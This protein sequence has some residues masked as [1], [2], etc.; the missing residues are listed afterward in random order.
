MLRASNHA[1]LAR[2]TGVLAGLLVA[3]YIG[4]ESPVSGMSMNPART[5]GS[6]LL[7]R[8]WTALW[9][10]F[11]APLAGML[12]AAKVFARAGARAACA[13]LHHHNRKRCI[14]NCN[15]RE[16][17]GRGS[18]AGEDRSVEVSGS[19]TPETAMLLLAS[20]L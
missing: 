19:K 15:F 10:Y 14:F 11:T 16:V 4:V 6:A 13:K 5:L 8:V 20:N 7:A 3:V 2:W 9:V 17:E 1:R 12:L 18:E